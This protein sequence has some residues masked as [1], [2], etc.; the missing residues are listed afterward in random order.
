M[1]KHSH[2]SSTLTGTEECVQYKEKKGEEGGR[3]RVKLTNTATL[4]NNN[5]ESI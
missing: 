3:S 2:N 4:R 1:Y 5:N